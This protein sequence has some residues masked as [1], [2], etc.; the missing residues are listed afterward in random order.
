VDG[1]V[2]LMV[3]L[4]RARAREHGVAMPLLASREDLERLAAGEREASPLL[5]GWRRTMVGDELVAL[6]DGTLCM[7]LSDGSLVIEPNCG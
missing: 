3:A 1:A 2:D 7:R 5:E 6:L 4:V